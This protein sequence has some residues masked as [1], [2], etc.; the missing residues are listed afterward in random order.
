MERSRVF[1]PGL[2]RPLEMLAVS[3]ERPQNIYA[4][5]L[6]LKLGYWIWRTRG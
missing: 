6:G 3:E 1:L 2:L 5:K 4:I